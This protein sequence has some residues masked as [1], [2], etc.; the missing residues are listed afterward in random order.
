[1]SPNR[2]QKGSESD[3]IALPPGHPRLIL[4]LRH[5]AH[6]Y[7]FAGMPEEAEATYQRVLD[8][9]RNST[10]MTSLDRVFTYAGIAAFYDP[11][12]NSLRRRRSTD[13]RWTSPR[14]SSRLSPYGP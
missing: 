5:L 7:D 14:S 8:M 9:M 13:E 4:D 2:C 6:C 12:I 3:P 1:L 10:G 11:E